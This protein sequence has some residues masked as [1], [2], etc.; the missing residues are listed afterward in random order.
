MTHI[1]HF[2]VVLHLSAVIEVAD[3]VSVAL[4]CAEWVHR[5]LEWWR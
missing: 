3:H 2:V 5:F 1:R 4:D